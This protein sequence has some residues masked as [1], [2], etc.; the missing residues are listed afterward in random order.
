MP[1]TAAADPK[2]KGIYK[3]KLTYWLRYTLDG[4]QHRVN[5][6]TR[7]FEEAIR[8][9]DALRGKPVKGKG[10]KVAWKSGDQALP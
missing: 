2:A 9:A 1:K 5:L 3:Q 6:Q 7:D 10:E 4:A 8:K